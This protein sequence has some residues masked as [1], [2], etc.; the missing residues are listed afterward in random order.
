MYVCNWCVL[1]EDDPKKVETFWS[2][3]CSALIVKLYIIILCDFFIWV[4]Y[5]IMN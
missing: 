4:V 1:P 3:C 2:L 5:G